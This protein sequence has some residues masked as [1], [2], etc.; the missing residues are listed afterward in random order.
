MCEPPFSADCEL[1]KRLMVTT[2][3]HIKRSPNPAH[4]SQVATNKKEYLPGEPRI[5]L[6]DP[7]MGAYLEEEL[8]TPELNQLSPHL[9]LV[10][11]QDSAHI[12]SL[13]HQKV[14]GREIIITEQPR[15]H[16]VW[17][18]D[19]VFI[20]PLPKYL[21][22][23]AFWDFYLVS[24][25]SSL[26]KS[27]QKELREAALGFLRSYSYLVRRRSDFDLAMDESHR[28]LPKKT[29]YSGFI[30]LIKS[31]ETIDDHMVSPRYHYGE[32]RLSRLNFWIKVFNFRF[33]YQKIEGQYSLYFARFY[34]PIL[35]LFGVLSVILSAMQ[36]IFAVLPLINDSDASWLDFAKL[37]RTFSIMTLFV[38]A[39]V[40][41]FF[42]L[43]FMS[44]ASRETIYALNDLYHNRRSTQ[45]K[46]EA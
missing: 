45:T 46:T 3:G 33:A 13:T 36:V 34:G 18:N 4:D 10:A 44:L 11:K 37:S 1:C 8:A 25:H 26:E 6:D 31:L 19:R 15:L 5:Q 23:R 35:F 38:V 2:D 17:Y 20:K 42:L 29:T 27:L 40:I 24:P 12:S 32:L 22:S 28:L 14:R 39:T 30:K 9:W 21:L 41:I 16:L 7:A 43:A